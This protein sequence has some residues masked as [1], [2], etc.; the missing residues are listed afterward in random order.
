MKRLGNSH[1]P[2]NAIWR[3]LLEIGKVLLLYWRNKLHGRL[4]RENGFGG[5]E[6]NSLLKT[7]FVGDADPNLSGRKDI[8]AIDRR[9]K[10]RHRAFLELND[11]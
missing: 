1:W 2:S 3:D 8:V 7:K 6:F 4:P 9:T 10:S 11:W 5:T